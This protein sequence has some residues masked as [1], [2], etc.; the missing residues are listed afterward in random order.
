MVYSKYSHY[1]KQA[2]YYNYAYEKYYLQAGA[3]YSNNYLVVNGYQLKAAGFTFG[4]GSCTKRGLGYQFNVQV[5]HRGTTNYG[6][7]K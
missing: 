3:Y 6:L 4:I 5:G 1:A 7:L 2:Q